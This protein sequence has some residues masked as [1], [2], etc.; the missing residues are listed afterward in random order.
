MHFQYIKPSGWL[1][2]YVRYYWILESEVSDGEVCERVIPTGNIE[3]MFH[4]KNPFQV[5][6]ASTPYHQPRSLITGIT[7]SYSDVSTHGESGVIAVTFYP[8][9]ACNFFRFPLSEIE[10]IHVPLR[11]IFNQEIRALE[12]KICEA[13]S[14]EKRVEIVEIFLMSRFNPVANRDL[15]LIQQGVQ[16][17]NRSRGQISAS[18]LSGELFLTG[19]SL[20]RKFATLLGKTPKQ[21]IRIIRFQGVIQD[22]SRLGDRQLTGLAYENGYFDQSHFVKDFKDLSGL[23]PKDFLALGPCQSDYFS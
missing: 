9:G 14:C 5:R 23:T 2:Q 17:I 8:H 18:V 11:D 22:L 3:L 19:K 15:S 21:F 16:L 4:Y 7:N 12:E 10:N 1:S 13:D 6:S 20:E